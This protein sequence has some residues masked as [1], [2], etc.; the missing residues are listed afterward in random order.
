M[1]RLYRTAAVIGFALSATQAGTA[2]SAFN[3]IP[4]YPEMRVARLGER[5]AIAAAPLC[6]DAVPRLGI[7]LHSRSQYGSLT[8]EQARQTF[9]IVNGTAILLVV[10]GSPADAAG[11]RAGDAVVAIDGTP[12]P[13]QSPT[14]RSSYA[15]T[16]AA[17]DQLDA[18]LADG[19]ANLLL[20]RP[21]GAGI[22]ISLRGTPGCRTRFQMKPTGGIAAEADGLYVQIG[23]RMV[24][25]ADADDVLSASLAHE[26]AH[27]M[28]RHRE[29]QNA[30]GMRRGLSRMFGRSA[31]LSRASELEA[32]RMVPWLL[33]LAGHDPTAG[34]RWLDL[35]E[36]LAGPA[37][38]THPGWNRRRQL[39]A[40]QLP[41]IAA[42]QAIGQPL[43]PPFDTSGAEQLLP[44]AG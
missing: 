18:A 36:R 40:E 5:L 43:R 24:E 16:R 6:R 21:D 25:S 29:R 10:P 20:R 8:N 22:A 2:V 4:D 32:D 17:L 14:T 30:A 26:L 34:L 11:V 28:L 13:L 41:L 37:A 19:T 31:A 15:P 9:P 23:Q 38:P 35:I 7:D 42:Q 3:V 12:L 27:N 33:A 44:D 39:I 1:T